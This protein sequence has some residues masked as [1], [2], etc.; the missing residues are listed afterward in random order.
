MLSTRH[1]LRV[2]HT[3]AV[4]GLCRSHQLQALLK[5]CC[6]GNTDTHGTPTR[7]SEAAAQ[8]INFILYTT[9]Y[10]VLLYTLYYYTTGALPIHQNPIMRWP[11]HNGNVWPHKALLDIHNT[12]THW[13]RRWLQQH[14]SSWGGGPLYLAS[15]AYM[16]SLPP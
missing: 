8:S 15:S 13:D 1:N 12:H 2:H 5:H 7:G 9:I 14:I 4:P 16:C 3:A 6:I 11:P 10:S